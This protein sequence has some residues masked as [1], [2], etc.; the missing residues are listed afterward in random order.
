MVL[1]TN[2]RGYLFS[3]PDFEE[4]EPPFLVLSNPSKIRSE[5]VLGTSVCFLVSLSSLRSVCFFFR[6]KKKN[7]T[8]YKRR[9]KHYT[10]ALPLLPHKGGIRM[11]EVCRNSS[12]VQSLISNIRS[13]D[14]FASF[15]REK[16]R[17]KLY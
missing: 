16:R 10:I 2:P 13:H 1:C 12:L 9:I 7:K 8:L 3:H 14:F 17:I 15:L 6:G 5:E 11:F 4:V